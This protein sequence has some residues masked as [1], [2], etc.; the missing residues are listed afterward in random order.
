MKKIKPITIKFLTLYLQK[1]EKLTKRERGVIMD[2]VVCGITP[3]Y[4]YENKEVSVDV[5]DRSQ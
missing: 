5:G 3:V 1:V 4:F 2:A